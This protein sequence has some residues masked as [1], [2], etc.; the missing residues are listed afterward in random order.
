[1]CKCKRSSTPTPAITWDTPDGHHLTGYDSYGRTAGWVIP[2]SNG[3]AKLYWYGYDAARG[4]TG[5]RLAKVDE[6]R[7]LEQAKAAL[8]RMYSP[9][10][11]D[12]DD[13]D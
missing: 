7:S 1:M 10:D 6:Y 12:E 8:E 2:E 5:A 9:M 11:D 4:T 3:L 13:D